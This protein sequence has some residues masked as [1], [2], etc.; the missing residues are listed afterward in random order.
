M[1]IAIQ[2]QD[3]D[4]SI[5]NAMCKELNVIISNGI[6]KKANRMYEIKIEENS[7]S[8]T[9]IYKRNRF[10]IGRKHKFHELVQQK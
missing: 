7:T 5:Q 4:S 3:N 9:S 8:I 2:N 10:W 6:V 1:S